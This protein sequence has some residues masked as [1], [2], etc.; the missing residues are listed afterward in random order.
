MPDAKE[1]D[2]ICNEVLFSLLDRTVPPTQLS[3]GEKA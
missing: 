2:S 1:L 3:K